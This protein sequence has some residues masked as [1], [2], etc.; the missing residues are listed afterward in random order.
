MARQIWSNHDVAIVGVG[1]TRQGIHPGVSPYELALAAVENA[2]AD[3]GVEDRS[4]IDGM[5]TA[6]QLD[7]SGID[8]VDMSRLMGLSPRV[9]GFLD[10]GTGGFTTQYGAMLIATG[11]CDIVVCAFAR[12]PPG[13]MHAL[14]GA[15]TYDANTGLVNAAAA[16]AF[17]WT[18]HMARYGSTEETLGRVMVTARR[19]AAMNP[20]AAWRDPLTLEDYLAQPCLMKPLRSYDI[21]K[22]TAGGV[23]VVMASAAIA[24]DLRRKPVYLHAV[25]RQQTPA[26]LDNE[27]HFLCRGMRSAAAQVYGAA[28]MTPKDVDVLLVSDAS[29]V[30]IPLTL[31]NYGFCEEGGSPDF[32]RSGAIGPGGSL[33]VNTHGGQLSEGYLVGWL[34]HAELVR[35]LRGEC[36]ERQV[37]GAR[38]AQYTTTGRFREDY[39]SSIYVTE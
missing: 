7:G 25:G 26:I 9:T 8:P 38:V 28:G 19:Y 13:A 33:P 1:T 18:Q 16:S 10:Y 6:R 22:V 11:V 3:A 35:Q 23:A 21:V 31:E 4:R 15:A 36:G 20:I 5:V 2:L 12:N 37:P 34:H 17:G 27:D 39:L 24:R 32:I 29:T 30:A 14:S